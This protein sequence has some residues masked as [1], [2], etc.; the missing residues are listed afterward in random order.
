MQAV[1][2]P[3]FP[4][5]QFKGKTAFGPHGD[6]IYEMDFIV[7]EIRKTLEKLNL[8]KN[9]IIMFGSDNGPEVGTTLNMRK[10]YKHDGAFPWRGF[11]RDQWEAGHRTPFIVHWPEKIKANSV[12]HQLISHTDVM[13][14]CAAIVDY[15]LPENAAEDSFNILPLLL[16]NQSEPI[17]QYLLTQTNKLNLA[18]R[19]GNW[20]FLDHQ[21]S[22]GN[23]Y[24]KRNLKHFITLEE[25][26]DLPGQLYKLDSDPGETTNLYEKHPEIVKE[27]KNKLKEF[28]QSGRSTP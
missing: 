23:N 8:A 28:Q 24:K 1:H 16:E 2:L 26:N 12:S 15:S 27:L 21:S 7:G 22:G 3:S 6:F 9:T 25:N 14:T 11:K 4:A 13:A 5:D 19:K 17:R 20:K 18:I 10:S